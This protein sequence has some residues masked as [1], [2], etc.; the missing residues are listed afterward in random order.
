MFTASDIVILYSPDST[1]FLLERVGEGR[2]C[3]VFVCRDNNTGTEV[4]VKILQDA[5][6]QEDIDR[7]VDFGLHQILLTHSIFLQVIFTTCSYLSLSPGFHVRGD[8]SWESIEQIH[9]EIP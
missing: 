8:S 2:F 1:D 9:C 3:E 5:C 7:E 6:K 4:A